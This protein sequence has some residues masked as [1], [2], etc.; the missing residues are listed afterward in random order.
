M[1]VKLAARAISVITIIMMRATTNAA[2]DWSLND[3]LFVLTM[4]NAP[5]E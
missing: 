4:F 2:P 5:Y 3:L 1:E